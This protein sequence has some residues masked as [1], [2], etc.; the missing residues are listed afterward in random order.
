MMFEHGLV[1]VI[2]HILKF[3]AISYE[4]NMSVFDYNE[5]FRIKMIVPFTLY[6]AFFVCIQNKKNV[7]CAGM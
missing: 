2:K 7:T 6:F 3:A 1:T 5:R 4:L